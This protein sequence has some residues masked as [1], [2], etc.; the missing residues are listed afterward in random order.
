MPGKHRVRLA[1]SRVQ[2]YHVM[3]S[4]IDKKY[5]LALEPPSGDVVP[6]TLQMVSELL[7]HSKESPRKRMI[8][9]LHKDEGEAVHRMFNALQPGTYIPPHR[10]RNP[11]KTETVLVISGGMLF[12]EFDEQG[13]V[14]NHMIVQPGTAVFGVDV[15]PGVYHTFFAFKPDTLLFEVKDGPYSRTD[16]KD[17]PEWAPAEGTPEAVEYL[18]DLIKGIMSE[19]AEPEVEQ[20]S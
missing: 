9:P 18:V 1:I 15:A 5:P 8:Q 10:H 19:Q 3:M 4:D 14:T 2:G 20:P 7:Q 11:A 17:I 6:I 16:D 12:I 13:N